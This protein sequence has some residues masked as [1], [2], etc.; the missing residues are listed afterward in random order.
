MSMP[1]EPFQLPPKVA[2][3]SQLSDMVLSCEKS[4]QQRQQ[5]FVTDARIGT[6][7]KQSVSYPTALAETYPYEPSIA[8]S[9]SSSVSSVFSDTASQ[10]SSASSNS[11]AEVDELS[12]D[13]S[14]APSLNEFNLTTFYPGV[15]HGQQPFLAAKNPA[16]SIQVPAQAPLELR[17]N[18][19]R[20]SLVGDQRPPPLVR[21]SERKVNFVDNLVGELTFPPSFF[22]YTSTAETYV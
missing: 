9:A 12:S 16:I 18:P 15:Y 10:T 6:L 14:N 13:H 21:Q 4:Y 1:W 2:H 20:C 19:R 3:E 8:S 7:Q 11:Q 22:P 17:R 5:P